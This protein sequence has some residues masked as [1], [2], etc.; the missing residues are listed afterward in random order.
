M[1]SMNFPFK[2]FHFNEAL[3]VLDLSMYPFLH[4]SIFQLVLYTISVPFSKVKTVTAV[5][6]ANI[7]IRKNYISCHHRQSFSYLL[8]E[9]SCRVSRV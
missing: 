2:I 9:G 5:L 7:Y 1:Y 8:S 6:C 4:M 3:S